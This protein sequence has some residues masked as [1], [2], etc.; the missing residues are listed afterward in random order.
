[1]SNRSSQLMFMLSLLLLGTALGFVI[2]EFKIFGYSAISD[3][4]KT[5]KALIEGEK[6]KGVGKFLRFTDI[7]VGE[8]PRMHRT[9]S[10]QR[11]AAETLGPRAL[12]PR[13]TAGRH[14]ASGRPE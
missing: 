9:R 5:G 2:G 14:L 1:M 4:I 13:G 3:G 8:T 6:G 12:R 7:P 11:T 10:G